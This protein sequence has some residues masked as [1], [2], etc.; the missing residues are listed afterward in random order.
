MALELFYMK[1]FS[2]LQ[3]LIPFLKSWLYFQAFQNLARANWN[4]DAASRYGPLL[5]SLP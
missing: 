3:I 1:S 2:I 4:R 5:K